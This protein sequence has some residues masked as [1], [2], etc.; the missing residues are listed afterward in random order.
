MIFDATR[1]ATWLLL[2]RHAAMLS[3]RR[4]DAARLPLIRRRRHAA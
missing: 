4:Y 3:M 1:H 2:L